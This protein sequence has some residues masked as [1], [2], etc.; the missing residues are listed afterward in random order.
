MQGKIPAS[1]T[2]FSKLEDLD[3]SG[4]PYLNGTLPA[5]IS[6]L[7]LLRLVGSMS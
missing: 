7:K 2:K 4:S 3:F 6:E 5:A 1:I